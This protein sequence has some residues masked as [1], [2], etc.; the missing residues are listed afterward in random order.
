[1]K[2][3]FS[4]AWILFLALM[5]CSEE[6]VDPAPSSSPSKEFNFEIIHGN[7]QTAHYN[8]QLQD[9]LVVKV[10]DSKGKPVQ[11]APVSFKVKNGSVSSDQLLTD[12]AGL[13][14]VKWTL[15]C[16]GNDNELKAYLHNA[17][18]NKIDSV[19][20][21]VNASIPKGWVK[22][23]GMGY[24]D[25]HQMVFR[26]HN[27]ILYVSSAMMI[28]TS[29][30]GGKNWQ[31]LENMPPLSM[32][33]YVFDIQFNSK[34]WM[35][36]ASRN[37]G[38]FYTKDHK[39]W[40]KINNGITDYRDPIAF[41]VEDDNLFISFYFGGLYRS[42][43]NGQSWRQ[44]LVDGK[45]Y[46]RYVFINRHPN[47]DLYLFDKWDNLWHST[48]N[49]TKWVDVNL[50]YKYTNYEVKDFVIDKDGT[51]YVGAGDA[52][53]SI[54]SSKTYQ[55]TMHS[56]YQWN[57]SS[58]HVNHI[59]IIND[60]VYYNVSSNPDPGIYSSQNWQKLDLGF[61]GRIYNYHLKSDGTF[62]IAS[63]DG[64]YYHNQ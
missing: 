7:N 56:Y 37:D 28:Y 35:Y 10:S 2:T 51:F 21:T 60:I 30:D 46:D 41:L 54:V 12:S 32:H 34:G 26:E 11:N 63:H 47:G 61:K 29:K 20:F 25:P 8:T 38:V 17:A 22:S 57:G 16:S 42:M 24:L 27:G 13:A 43:D 31:E 59:N 53:I 3:R 15:G 62:L 64:I 14:H 45:S 23:C 58:Q 44:L 4:I 48:T 39:N 33:S 55:G 5:G 52:T 36:V 50:S 9:S 40:Q 1:M 19:R 49:G 6:S 18:S